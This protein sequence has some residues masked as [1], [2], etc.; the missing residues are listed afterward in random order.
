MVYG[1][2]IRRSLIKLDNNR[3]TTDIKNSLGSSSTKQDVS[4]LTMLILLRSRPSIGNFKGEAPFFFHIPNCREGK[5]DVTRL[6]V[7]PNDILKTAN[8]HYA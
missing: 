2:I 3:P 5:Y 8:F 7:N 1:Y 4:F 6:F